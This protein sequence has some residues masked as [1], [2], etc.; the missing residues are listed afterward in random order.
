MGEAIYQQQK[1][2]RTADAIRNVFF[3]FFFNHESYRNEDIDSSCSPIFDRYS[4]LFSRLTIKR[5]R[6][7]KRRKKN[8][9]KWMIGEVTIL[10]VRAG[11]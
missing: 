2:I 6:K 10:F 3:F 5:R 7:K 8:L 1:T 4:F 11:E 9:I